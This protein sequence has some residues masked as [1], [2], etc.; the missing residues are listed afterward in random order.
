MFEVQYC[1]TCML[2]VQ[3]DTLLFLGRTFRPI[4]NRV[5]RR[6]N[7]GVKIYIVLL[8][9]S[10]LLSETRSIGEVDII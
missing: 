6:N 1:S 4:L 9:G 7:F 5:L 10:L 2:H 8:Q 3:S